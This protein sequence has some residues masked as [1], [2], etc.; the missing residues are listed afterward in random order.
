M[1]NI[2]DYVVYKKDVC[3]IIDIKENGLNNLNYYILVPISDSSLKISVPTDNKC[4]FLR[5]HI[6]KKQLNEIIENIPNIGII[7]NHDR[8]IE[9]EYRNLLNSNKHEDLIKIIKTTYLRNKERIDNNK[10]TRDSDNTYFS[11][12]EKYLYNEFSIVLGLTYEETKD[13]VVKKVAE[14]T[15]NNS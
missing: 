10:K 5:N 12:A 11:Q 14:L 1:F 8:M 3:K 2:D 13:Y 7:E 6:T 15:I 4:V 9:N